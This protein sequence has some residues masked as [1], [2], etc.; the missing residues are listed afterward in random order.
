MAAADSVRG[1]G[2][3]R[4]GQQ[5][6]GQRLAQLLGDMV[7]RRAP[8]LR[9][10]AFGRSA[11]LWPLCETSCVLVHLVLLAGDWSRQGLAAQPRV[12]REIFRLD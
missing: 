11:S 9:R 1:T 12:L 8:A 7:F 6:E 2:R 5:P 4:C 10:S 3:H